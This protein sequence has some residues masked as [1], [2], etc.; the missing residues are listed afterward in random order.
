[1]QY[2]LEGQDTVPEHRGILLPV[3]CRLNPSI[4]DFI[5]ETVYEDRLK[6]APG[7]WQQKL[8]RPLDE[9]LD[10]APKGIGFIDVNHEGRSQQSDEEGEVIVGLFHRALK[11]HYTDSDGIERDM[12]MDDIMFVVFYNAQ[13]NYLKR[14][15]PARART[16]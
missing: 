5:S 2:L 3:S 9:N 4:C 10:I 11:N 7:N 16:R 6:S 12:T 1:M 13:V 14:A 15:L 8:Y